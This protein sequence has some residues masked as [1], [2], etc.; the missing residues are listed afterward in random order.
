MAVFYQ[1]V[2]GV[3]IWK[4][5]T[6]RGN[7]IVTSYTDIVLTTPGYNTVMLYQRRRRWYNIQPLQGLYTRSIKAADKMIGQH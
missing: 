6:V 3:N 4:Y 5:F 2:A 1:P 7:V